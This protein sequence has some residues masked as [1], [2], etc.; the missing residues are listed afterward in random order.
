MMTEPNGRSQPS[1]SILFVCVANSARSQMAEGLARTLARFP[2]HVA[3]AGT[4]PASHIDPTALEVMN[5]I[6][7]D[8]SSHCPKSMTPNEMFRYDYVITM[9]CGVEAAC[10]AAFGGITADWE[11]PDPKGK[12]L[13]VYRAIRDTIRQHVEELLRDIEPSKD[14]PE[15]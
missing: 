15:E 7:I 1:K 9:G 13:H 6:G 11:L 12:P 8:I 10:P 14:I 2:V 3:S 4:Q 5:E